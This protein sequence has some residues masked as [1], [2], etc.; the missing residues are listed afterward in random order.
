[1]ANNS[2]AN[3]HFNKTEQRRLKRDIVLK[4]AAECFN[5]KGI[6]GT[7]L[8]DVARKLNITDAALYYYVKNKEELVTLC[9]MRA[10]DLGEG[11]LE[12]AIEEGD[13]NLERLQLYIRYQLEEVCG[14]NGPVAILSEIPALKPEH[15]KTIRARSSA[16]T[17]RITQLLVDG[18]NEGSLLIDDPAITCDAILGAVNWTPKWFK[19]NS[20]PSGDQIADAFVQTF[21]QGL[22]PR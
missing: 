20:G 10:L 15:Q 1:M 4:V 6:S 14:D 22:L 21:T 11:A 19:P 13:N 16:H 7:S 17:K 12:R 9:Y 5:E 8:K 18:V 2:E 3:W